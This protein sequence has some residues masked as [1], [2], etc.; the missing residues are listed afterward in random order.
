MNNHVKSKSVFT[1]LPPEDQQRI[2]ALCNEH[3]YDQVVEIVARPRPEGLQLKTS[4][5]ALC[6]FYCSYNSAARKAALLDQT[7]SSLQYIRLA[8]SGALPTAILSLMETTLF[9]SLRSGT[10]LAKLK[11][12]FAILR[13]YQKGFLAEER[14]RH[15]PGLNQSWA[16]SRHESRCAQNSHYDFI[17]L[18]SAGHPLEIEPLSEEQLNKLNYNATTVSPDAIA[19]LDYELAAF[20]RL[21]AQN[22]SM[23]RRIPSSLF[24]ERR[25]IYEQNLRAS[26]LTPLEFSIQARQSRLAAEK[27]ATLPQENPENSTEMPRNSTSSTKSRLKP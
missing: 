11:R 14:Y 6:R 20:G 2:I 26:G 19:Q 9:E 13:D 24:E 1:A 4:S 22:L 15:T 16:L 5:S 25:A 17:P 21:T 10:P 7:A 27:S 23:D 12:E 18:D 8:G 3:T